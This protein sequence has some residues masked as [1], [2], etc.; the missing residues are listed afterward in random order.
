MKGSHFAIVVACLLPP[1]ALALVLMAQSRS[2]PDRPSIAVF[3]LDTT[4][5]DAVS[6]YGGIAGTTPTFDGLAAQG[7]LYTQAYAQA[8]WTLPSHATL[9]TGLLPSEHGAG[10]R[11]WRLADA[12]ETLAERLYAHGYETAGFSENHFVSEM[13]NLDQGFRS[14]R[15]IDSGERRD[16]VRAVREWIDARDPERPFFLFA[17]LMDAHSPYEVR[18]E[19]PFVP[20]DVSTVELRS[21]SQS[22]APQPLCNRPRTAEELAMLR[23]LYLGD[24][25]AADAK[26]GA[27]WKLVRDAARRRLITVVTSDHGEHLG[28]HGLMGHLFSVWNE[29]LHVPLVVHGLEDARPRRLDT[30]VQIADLFPTVLQWAG[31][32]PGRPLPGRPLPVDDDGGADDRVLTAQFADFADMPDDGSVLASRTQDLAREVRSGCD[33]AD[34]VFGNMRSAIRY[35]FKLLQIGGEEAELYDL[36]SDRHETRDLAAAQ[37]ARVA[38]IVRLLP[39]VGENLEVAAARQEPRPT[40]APEVIE[41]LRALGYLE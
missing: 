10:I 9:F 15:L 2:I 30:P 5:F 11:A 22:L 21:L 40:L 19:N 39:A 29:L 17:N 13:T 12:Q 3:V 20:A 32:T 27:I 14:F 41:R 25:Q 23:A 38:E 28:E 16:M 6:A 37:P 35:P 18:A 4:R 31:D 1:L 34:R 33:P 7:V 26:L 36:G 24:V 8:P